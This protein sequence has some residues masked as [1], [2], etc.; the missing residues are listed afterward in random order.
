MRV[1]TFIDYIRDSDIDLS[2]PSGG[3]VYKPSPRALDRD[4]EGNKL[5][6]PKILMVI[7]EDLNRVFRKLLTNVFLNYRITREKGF[8][9]FNSV[10]IT[11]ENTGM[12]LNLRIVKLSN[13]SCVLVGYLSSKSKR[14]PWNG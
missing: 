8:I 7:E 1:S 13:K 5:N 14:V 4:K 2:V 10:A 6:P 12:F 11:S 3:L 9:D